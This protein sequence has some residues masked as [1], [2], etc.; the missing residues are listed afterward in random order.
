MYINNI[1]I[2][3]GVVILIVSINLIMKS[4]QTKKP[5]EYYENVIAETPY[6]ELNN[7]MSKFNKIYKKNINS[8]IG[9]KNFVKNYY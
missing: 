2:I 7:M 3:V 5:K 9:L 8:K 4:K 1:V 6:P